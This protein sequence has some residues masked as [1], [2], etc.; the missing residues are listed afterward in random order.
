MQVAN[1]RNGMLFIRDSGAV[2]YH[3]SRRRGEDLLL[4]HG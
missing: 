1:L 3:W 2:N 4:S